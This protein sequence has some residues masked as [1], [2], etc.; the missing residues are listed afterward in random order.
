[1]LAGACFGVV[2]LDSLV[3]E[4][5][6]EAANPLIDC[7]LGGSIRTAT[8]SAL[9]FLAT[10]A[11]H[12]DSPRF[13]D[14]LLEPTEIYVQPIVVVARSDAEVRR[15]CPITSCGLGNLLRLEGR[16]GYRDRRSSACRRLELIQEMG[17]ISDRNRRRSSP[18]AGS[19]SRPLRQ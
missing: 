10:L 12:T 9:S 5:R 13:G 4:R 18:G 6:N 11:R 19:A 8:P 17:T 16:P 1:M 14:V 3:T 7:L 15:S 2:A